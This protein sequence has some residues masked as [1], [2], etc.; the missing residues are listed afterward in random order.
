MDFRSRPRDMQA[1]KKNR[2]RHG[3]LGIDRVQSGQQGPMSRQSP[4]VSG[5]KIF[6]AKRI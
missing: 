3:F 2:S 5:Q 6:M 1:I 4:V